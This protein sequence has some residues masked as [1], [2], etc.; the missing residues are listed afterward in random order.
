M[1]NLL[2]LTRTEL[3]T[4]CTQELG[5]PRFRAEQLWQW[6]W[7]KGVAD[8]D[9]MTNIAKPLREALKEKCE[10]RWPEIEKTQVSEDG[11]TKF[12]F[13]MQDGKRIESVIIP[14]HDRYS[15]CLS[16]QAGCAMGCTFCNTGLMGFERNL[17]HGEILGQVLAARK[18]LEDNDLPPLKNLVFMGMGE[19]LLNLDTLLRVL[20][21]LPDTKGLN[22]SWRRSMVSTVGFPDQLRTL[23]D[24]EM[25]LPAISLHA[26]NQ[27]L[28]EQIMPK[29]ARF[30][31][32]DLVAALRAYPMRPRERITIEYLLLGGVNDRPEHARELATLL[33]GL[34]CKVNLI[35]YNATED[36]PY[37]APSREDAEAFQNI[38][39]QKGMT[40]F[41]RRSMGADIAAACGQLKADQAK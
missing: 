26:P 28:R 23:G 1:I 6:M 12:L 33:S 14:M 3:E 29:A 9:A 41:I 31:I 8:F 5:L 10:V 21:T 37:H 15:Q 40:A 32:D 34:R 17:T 24:S 19:P 18:H 38:L 30:H 7:Q 36:M 13:R 4:F 39:K 2:D 27:A 25:A 11:T 16:T 22:I 35:S 20:G